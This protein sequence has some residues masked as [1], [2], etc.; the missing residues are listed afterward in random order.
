MTDLYALLP[1]DL[2]ALESLDPLADRPGHLLADV[3]GHLL[4]YVLDDGVAGPQ[5]LHTLLPRDLDTLRLLHLLWH[6]LANLSRNRSII[7]VGDQSQAV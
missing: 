7:L 4:T 6:I 1:W 3:P 5:H 2:G